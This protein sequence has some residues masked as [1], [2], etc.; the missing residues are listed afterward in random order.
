MA[1]PRAL[2]RDPE[3][4]AQLTPAHSASA[5]RDDELRLEPLKGG[6]GADD[7]AKRAA[8]GR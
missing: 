5:C 6:S 3:I 4:R 7:L 1:L 8:G 2:R